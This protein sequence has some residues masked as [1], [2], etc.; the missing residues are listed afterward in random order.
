M[1]DLGLIRESRNGF[2]CDLAKSHCISFQFEGERP[3]PSSGWHDARSVM[4]V[5]DHRANTFAVFD[6]NAISVLAD[7]EDRQSG[8][9]LVRC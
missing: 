4:Q 6:F 5:D 1:P 7:E 9:A 8:N 2:I 3:D